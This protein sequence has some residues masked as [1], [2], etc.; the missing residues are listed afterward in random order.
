MDQMAKPTEG[1][2]GDLI[3]EILRRINN[4]DFDVATVRRF[5]RAINEKL[6]TYENNQ[7]RLVEKYT[8]RK[9]KHTE[10]ATTAFPAS[11]KKRKGKQRSAAAASL[12]TLSSA[13][14]AASSASAAASSA[15]SSSASP[16]MIEVFAKVVQGH[17]KDKNRPISHAYLSMHVPYS[18][19]RSAH[20]LP[21]LRPSPAVEAATAARLAAAARSAA[22]EGPPPPPPP[23]PLPIPPLPA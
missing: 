10:N 2:S 14:A 17:S 12:T 5:A 16:R 7:A 3:A 22:G 20:A 15:S 4:D 13:A 21:I 9:R 18:S 19:L 11:S 1:N 8:N 6:V 23:P